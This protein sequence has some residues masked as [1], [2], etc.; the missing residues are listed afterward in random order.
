MLFMNMDENRNTSSQVQGKVRRLQ[1]SLM[2][3]EGVDADM[4]R[5][6]LQDL[7]KRDVQMRDKVQPR[8]AICLDIEGGRIA[9][10]SNSG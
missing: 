7:R 8:P 10:V 9:I 6:A 1:E 3:A 5:N 2:E 4:F